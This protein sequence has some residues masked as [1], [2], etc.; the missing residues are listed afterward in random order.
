MGVIVFL[1]GGDGC[2]VIG[3]VVCE[4]IMSEVMV[5]LGVVIICCLVVVIIG[6]MVYW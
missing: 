6:E 2:C 1:C 4:F 3:L 5:V